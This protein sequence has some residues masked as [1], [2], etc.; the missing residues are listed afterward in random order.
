MALLDRA[1]INSRSKDIYDIAHLGRSADPVI[2]SEAI[3]NTFRKRNLELSGE[4]TTT[5]ESIDTTRLKIGWKKATAHIY[6][7]PNFDEC[8]ETTIK[9][10]QNV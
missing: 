2:L 9:L 5:L 8:W 4:I 7:A 10:F 6:P 3:K 1:E